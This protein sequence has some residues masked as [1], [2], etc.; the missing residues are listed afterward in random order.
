MVVHARGDGIRQNPHIAKDSVPTADVS[1]SLAE[2]VM[3][4]ADEGQ[5]VQLERVKADRRAEGAAP[6]PPREAEPLES[7]P[8]APASQPESLAQRLDHALDQIR[9][10]MLADHKRGRF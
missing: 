3:T 7:A 5:V 4:K 10:V 1:R 6:E 8:P 9:R 2:V